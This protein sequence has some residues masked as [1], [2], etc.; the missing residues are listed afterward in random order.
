MLHGTADILE[1]DVDALGT[2][3]GELL[4]KVACA[5]IDAGVEAEL[6][7]D[8]AAFLRPPA[9]PTARAPFIFAICPTTEPTAPEAAA[10]TT[11][12]PGFGWPISP[13]PT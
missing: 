11:V 1:I 2:R 5:M 6:L 12:S 3:G 13:S 4:R 7:G 8:E 10:T 9:I